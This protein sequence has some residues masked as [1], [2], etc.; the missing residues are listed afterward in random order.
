MPERT[1]EDGCRIEYIV[2]DAMVEF[3]AFE[4]DRELFRGDVRW[5]GCLNMRTIGNMHSCGLAPF[6]RAV[7][8]AYDLG[9]ELGDAWEGDD[10]DE[11]WPALRAMA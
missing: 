9:A 10:T 2:H 6:L 1:T 4:D 8:A 5:D 3:A 7:S 11:L